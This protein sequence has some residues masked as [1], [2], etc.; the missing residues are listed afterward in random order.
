MQGRH[1]VGLGRVDVGGLAHK[2]PDGFEIA[3]HGGVDDGRFGLRAAQLPA[4]TKRRPH[5]AG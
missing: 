5:S 4:A 2:R 3:V 1:A